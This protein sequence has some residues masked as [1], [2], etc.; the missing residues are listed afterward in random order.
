MT[1]REALKQGDFIRIRR[2]SSEDEWCTGI[3]E[4]ASLNGESI[5][6]R[7]FDGALRPD[8]GGIVTGVIAFSCD[9]EKGTATELLTE[10]EMEVEVRD[11]D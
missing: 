10:T 2:A 3:V 7:V 6:M 8:G 11:E 1:D 5:L 4:R 9:I